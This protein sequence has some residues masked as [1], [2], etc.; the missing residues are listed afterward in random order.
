MQIQFGD[1]V[2]A[3]ARLRLL[4]ATTT[5]TNLNINLYLQQVDAA[6]KTGYEGYQS[7]S[8]I[9]SQMVIVD[10]TSAIQRKEMW[11]AAGFETE[12]TYLQNENDPTIYELSLLPLCSGNP[13][14][15]GYK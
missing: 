13:R 9:N 14:T 15:R 3:S 4:I 2:S 10:N 11:E 12:D 8:V 7:V 6:D 5:A 1:S